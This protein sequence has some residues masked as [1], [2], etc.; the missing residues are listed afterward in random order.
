MVPQIGLKLEIV[1]TLNFNKR[2]TRFCNSLTHTFLRNH[3]EAAPTGPF[4]GLSEDLPPARQQGSTGQGQAMRLGQGSQGV[5][6]RVSGF[7]DS[8]FPKIRVPCFGGPYDKD[9]TIKGL[10][11]FGLLL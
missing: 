7:S 6:C 3:C 1:G 10:T 9:P 8:C 4:E 5:R 2:F 11:M